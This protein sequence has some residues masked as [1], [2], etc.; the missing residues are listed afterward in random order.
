MRG[1]MKKADFSL[2]VSS[3]Q[4]HLLLFGMDINNQKSPGKMISY[5]IQKMMPVIKLRHMKQI[6]GKN[7]Y[8]KINWSYKL[9]TGI[10][11]VDYNFLKLVHKNLD[12]YS[13]GQI[14][15][16]MMDLFFYFFI[17]FGSCWFDELK[18]FLD[19]IKGKLR[20]SKAWIK[21][22]QEFPK[23]FHLRID[24]DSKYNVIHIQKE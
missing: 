23:L 3:E 8:E 22:N 1:Y 16:S 17:R 12:T 13:I 21:R 6:V 18:A 10:T 4:Y 19:K 20:S 2:L 11:K 24:Y 14:I 9:H 15:R 7:N 5:I